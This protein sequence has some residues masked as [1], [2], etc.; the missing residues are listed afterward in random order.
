MNGHGTGEAWGLDIT[1]EGNILTTG[2]DNKIICFDPN[3]NKTISTGI[4]NTKAGK[5][6]RIGGAST[7]SRFPPN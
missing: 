6:K 4:V 1:P 2:D 3:Q 5:K 7:L